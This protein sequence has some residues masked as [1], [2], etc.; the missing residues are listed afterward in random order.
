MP[1]R[2]DSSIHQLAYCDM[3]EK[4]DILFRRVEKAMGRAMRPSSHIAISR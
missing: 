2:N 3:N 4:V 1:F